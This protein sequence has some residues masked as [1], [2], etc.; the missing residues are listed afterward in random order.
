MEQSIINITPLN[1]NLSECHLKVLYHGLNR[2]GSYISKSV[3]EKL[4]NK[5]PGTPIVGLYIEDKEDFDDHGERLVVENGKYTVKKLTKPFGYVKE[6]TKVWWQSFE[7]KGEIKDYLMCE[8]Y[9]WTKTYPEVKRVL[10]KGNWQ[11][12]EFVPE[13]LVGEWSQLNHEKHNQKPMFMVEDAEFRALCI[14]GEDVEPCFETAAIGAPGSLFMLND[15]E[16][17]SDFNQIKYSIEKSLEEGGSEVPEVENTNVTD[18]SEEA[19]ETVA[20]AV[21]TIEAEVQEA[22][23]EEEVVT[24]EVVEAIEEEVEVVETEEVVEEIA[25]PSEEEAAPEQGDEEQEE[26]QE[27]EQEQVELTE[28]V[29]EEE[30][31]SE[32]DVQ[33]EVQELRALFYEA[34]KELEELKAQYALATEELVALRAMKEEIDTKA[35]EE[36]FAKFYMLDEEDVNPVRE[37]AASLT[38]DEIEKELSV[39]AFRKKVNFSLLEEEAEEKEVITSFTANIEDTI[40][41]WVRQVENMKKNRK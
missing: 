11:S 21:E 3:A 17:E 4:A 41:A 22:L 10:E 31:A 33:S 23:T 37:Q 32:N 1:P 30:V 8:G 29:S 36:M 12:M 16:I 9:L 40:P 6:G 20:E 25:E 15:S 2:N 18:H 34:T 27:S 39:I 38:V 14:L 24:E 5:L 28:E 13:S 35:K 19:V 7:E 26:V